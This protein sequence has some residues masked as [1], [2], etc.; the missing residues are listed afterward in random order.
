MHHSTSTQDASAYALA[1]TV[2]RQPPY[3]SMS[4][5]KK[6]IMGG[7][8]SSGLG[9]MNVGSTTSVGTAGHT[10]GLNSG[11]ADFVEVGSSL[12]DVSRLSMCACNFAGLRSLMLMPVAAQ[13][14][15]TFG[16]CPYVL[17]EPCR[18]WT[19]DGVRG[20]SMSA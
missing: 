5:S 18:E 6:L 2:N 12:L 16:A 4:G 7:M 9:V 13:P 17:S 20:S 1:S 11:S 14:S 8:R 19:R 10:A 15:P 3:T